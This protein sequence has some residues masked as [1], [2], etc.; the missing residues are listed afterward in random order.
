[1]SLKRILI[2]IVVFCFLVSPVIVFAQQNRVTTK[3]GN[4]PQNDDVITAAKDL[5]SAY[6]T[7]NNGNTRDPKGT[8]GQCLREQLFL[9]GYSN[10]IIAAFKTRHENSFVDHG[11][12][13]KCTECVGY[14]GLVLTLLSGDPNTLQIN[15]TA[16]P[17]LSQI[18][19]GRIVFSKV[20]PKDVQ[21]GDIGAGRG[22]AFIVRFVEEGSVGIIA[23]ES[24]AGIANCDVTDHKRRVNDG[25]TYFRKM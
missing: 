18:T 23:Y 11:D 2:T 10:A 4:P 24:N 1:M 6:D 19:A 22:H 21:P 9:F 13:T 15:A 20:A 7:C 5:K 8:L 14:V 25:Y 17:S 3:V 16:I 12:W